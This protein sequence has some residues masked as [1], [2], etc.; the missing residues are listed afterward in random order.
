MG[1][2][3]IPEHILNK[4]G[5]LTPAEFEIMKRHAPI[6]ADILAVIGL[7]YAVAPIVRHHHESWDGTGYPD[8]LAGDR[9][10]IGSR[11][12]AVVDCFDALTSDRPYRPRMDDRDALQIV[13][14]RRGTMYDPRVV[15]AFFEMHGHEMISTSAQPPPLASAVSAPVRQ[16]PGSADEGRDDR[17]LQAFFNLGRALSGATSTSQL[18]EVLWM[19]LRAH[20]PASVFVLYGYDG[21]NDT[22]VAVHTAG[23]AASGVDTTPIPLGDRVSGWVAATGQ[24]VMNSDARL[25]LGEPA[26]ER[27]PLRSAL[28]V[29]I[30]VD[31]RT[32]GVLSFYAETS[33]A[34]DDADRRLVEAAGKALASTAPNLRP[35][36][37]AQEIDLKS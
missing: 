12:I 14:D 22:I 2:L 6:G 4:P 25:D 11:I 8:R 36:V 32:A 5:R 37:A 29:P 7:P 13:R 15:D 21:A 18:G 9:I 1:K 10:P 20:L 23:A 3:A 27:S 19:H 16:A 28:A 31:G 33:N 26:R 24:T 34:F 35:E 17:D 30:V